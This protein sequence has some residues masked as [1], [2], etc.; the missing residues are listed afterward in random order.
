MARLTFLTGTMSSGKT[1]HLLQSHFNVEDAFPGQVMLI[2][3]HDRSG[4]SVCSTRM[5]GMSLS[6]GVNDDV[7]LIDLISEQEKTT[8]AKVKFIFVDEVQFFTVKQIE[9]LAHLVDVSDIEVNAYGLLTSYKGELFSA[10]KRLI[11]LADRIIQISNGMRCWCG[12]R[13]THNALY[14]NGKSVSSGSETIVDN[15][16]DIDYRVM[17]RRHFMEHISCGSHSYL[18][19]QHS[20]LL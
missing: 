4:D 18:N 6:I 14:L 20:S 10:A 5:G 11:E 2:N 13:A 7:N 8:D 9:Q 3:K 12:A 1:T 16:D 19:I 15:A 17:C